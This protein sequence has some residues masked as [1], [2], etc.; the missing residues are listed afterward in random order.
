MDPT[1][2]IAAGNA[3]A[4]RLERRARRNK[5]PEAKK[6]NQQEARIVRALTAALETLQPPLP[7]SK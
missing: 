6:G 5:D 3:L 7:R 4:D 1:V 2:L